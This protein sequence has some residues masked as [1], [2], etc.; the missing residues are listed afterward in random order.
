M[1]NIMIIKLFFRD[2]KNF[3]FPRINMINF[4]VP[5]KGTMVLLGVLTIGL[6]QNLAGNPEW[7]ITQNTDFQGISCRRPQ[8]AGGYDA[9]ANTTF[10]CWPGAGMNSKVRA[11]DHE[12]LQFSRT[13]TLPGYGSD[14]FHNYPTMILDKAGHIHIFVASHGREG[15]LHYRSEEPRS[16]SSGWTDQEIDVPATYQLPLATPDGSLYCIYRASRGE[17]GFNKPLELISSSNN[18]KTW[19]KPHQLINFQR[20]DKRNTIYC[21]Q[22]EFAPETPDL[23]PRLLISWTRAGPYFDGSGYY[24]NTHN[25]V[26]FAYLSLDDGNMYSAGHNNLGTTVN[27]G[28]EAQQCIVF[29]HL[30]QNHRAVG[31]STLTT[32]DHE[33]S[34]VVTYS[35]QKNQDASSIAM[36]ST[37]KNGTWL[38]DTLKTEDYGSINE[39]ERLA[40]GRHIRLY[41]TKR[42][43]NRLVAI[44]YGPDRKLQEEGKLPVHASSLRCIAIEPSHPQ[45]RLF[46]GAFAGPAPNESYY[47]ERLYYPTGY[48][49]NYL[50]GE[51]PLPHY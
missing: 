32:F 40:G 9:T 21:A 48:Q 3:M 38:R 46:V 44:K 31:Y 24:D 22:V 36:V 12:A 5:V 30:E 10:F 49:A 11:Y 37:F 8:G 26:Y 50:I 13:Y 19:S 15:M 14:D 47:N 18:G 16:I 28:K 29:D 39:V 35:Y 6:H 27:S 41:T 4:F 51:E 42:E 34:P 1:F 33:G 43:S 17:S 2:L 23:P 45:I 7:Y 20:K 25:D